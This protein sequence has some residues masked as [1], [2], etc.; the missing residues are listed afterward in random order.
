MET[1]SEMKYR[2]EY[3]YI[4]DAMQN[5]VLKAR[6]NAIMQRDVHAGPEGS[7]RIRSLYFDDYNDRCYYENESGI[8]ER[9]KYRIR[10]YNSDSNRITLEKKSKSRGM[11]LKTACSI[12]EEECRLFM[13]GKF[14]RITE[15][16]PIMQKQLYLEM[17]GREMRPVVIVEYLRYPFIEKN[18]N[19]RITFDESISS[20]NAISEFLREKISV[21][22]VM[23]KGQGIL[24]VK[25][26]EFLPDYL[27]N[28]MQLDS[29]SRSSFSKYYLCRKYNTYG[30][31]RV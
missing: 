20:S 15:D 7:Y 2:H 16:M 24:E 10:I 25:W 29:L 26:D 14:P 9:D 31:V 22:P 17:M 12:T 11:T 21:R 28:H 6:A 4:C 19:V 1:S 13:T 30:G 18:G 27:K 5:A 3:K 23:E 8:G